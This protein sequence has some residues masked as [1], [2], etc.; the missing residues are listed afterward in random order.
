MT[1]AMERKTS[2]PLTPIPSEA[3][4]EASPS[5]VLAILPKVKCGERSLAAM[6][7][8]GPSQKQHPVPARANV[9]STVW[10]QLEGR[11]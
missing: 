4:S 6:V 2:S 9:D 7:M 10:V 3:K 1:A 8:Y 5:A 11:E